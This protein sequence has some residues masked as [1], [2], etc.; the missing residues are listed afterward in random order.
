MQIRTKNNGTNLLPLVVVLFID[1]IIF[2]QVSKAYGL[3]TENDFLK[4]AIILLLTFLAATKLF[5][6]VLE[7]K[8]LSKIII[9]LMLLMFYIIAILMVHNDLTYQN[10][11]NTLTF[12]II[13]I[14]CYYTLYGTQMFRNIVIIQLVFAL[15]LFLLY[16]YSKLYIIQQGPQIINSIYYLVFMLPFVY[17]IKNSLLKNITIFL[18]FIAVIVS[19]KRTALLAFVLSLLIYILFDREKRRKYI[20]KVTYLFIIMLAFSLV[21]NYVS[22]TL[23]YDII[24]K[25]T[26]LTEDGGSGRSQI[27]SMVINSLL[28]SNLVSIIFGHGYNSVLN[29]TSGFSS[30]NDLL[31]II[32]SFGIVGV[33]LYSYI[34]YLLIKYVVIFTKNQYENS[35]SFVASI[36]IFIIFSMVSSLVFVVSYVNLLS[37]FWVMCIAD[38]EHK[39]NKNILAN[40]RGG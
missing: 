16:I 37:L 33:I 7:T 14:A 20:N 26:M 28:H 2:L 24:S 12:P 15:V 29:V 25:F 36:S 32:F 22:G 19:L 35:S 1:T 9:N 10:L 40:Y 6:V 23:G 21:Y 38:Y 18:I 5:F 34:Y 13:F 31:D 4:F 3:P 17:C 8:K 27:F 11:I 30:H 39:K